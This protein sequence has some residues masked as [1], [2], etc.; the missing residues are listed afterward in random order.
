MNIIRH[1]YD[2]E[3]PYLSLKQ[4]R[5][6]HEHACIVLKKSYWNSDFDLQFMDDRRARNLLFVQAQYEIEQS[7][8]LFA[9]DI[10]QQLEIL[11]ENNSFKDYLLLACTLKFYGYIILKECSMRYPVDDT[12]KQKLCKCF[13]AIGNKEIVCCINSGQNS[14]MKEISL[15]VT[16]IRCWKLNCTKQ[17]MSIELEYLIKKL[18]NLIVS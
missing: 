2:F 7:K 8:N 15:K 17:E 13:V 10:H 1:I 4:I 18:V 12:S 3:S 5:K 14:E 11:R 16:R 6:V 9:S